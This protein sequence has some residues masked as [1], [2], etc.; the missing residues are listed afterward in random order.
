MPHLLAQVTFPG[1]SGLPEDVFVN[2]YHFSSAS[3]DVAAGEVVCDHLVELYTVAAAGGS[4]ANLA[5]CSFY[6]FAVSHAALACKIKVYDAEQQ[7]VS[8]GV[9]QPRT[10]L[11]QRSFTCTGV[12]T[13]YTVDMP[14]EVALCASFWGVSNTPRR[15]GR[16]Y[17]GPFG[18][19]ALANGTNGRAIPTIV[20][21]QSVAASFARLINKSANTQNLAVWSRGRYTVNKV[22]QPPVEGMLTIVTDGWVDDAWDTQRRRGQAASLRT[23][24]T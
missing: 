24:F 10:I 13:G 2:T 19:H 12:G 21:R 8:Q 23:V 11:T 1:A 6:G 16:V 3:A 15:R 7:V 4:P 20:L 22:P 18:N 14:A 5:I 17:L 9:I